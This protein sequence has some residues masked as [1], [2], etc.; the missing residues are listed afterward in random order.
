MNKIRDWY[1]KVRTFF[2][3][4]KV[5]IKKVTWPSRDELTNYTMVVIF[6]VILISAFIGVIDKIFG[7]FLEMFLRI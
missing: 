7:L 5:E 2:K 4:V 6:V 1:E 3:E